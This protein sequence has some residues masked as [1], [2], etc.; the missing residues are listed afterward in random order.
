MIW[1]CMIPGWGLNFIVQVNND[2][3]EENVRDFLE[4]ILVSF[5]LH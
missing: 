1:D 5:Y 2:D 3:G 4:G